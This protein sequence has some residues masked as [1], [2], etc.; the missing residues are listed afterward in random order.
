M[1]TSADLLTAT[2]NYSGIV[3]VLRQNVLRYLLY[4]VL[5]TL[6]FGQN[7]VMQIFPVEWRREI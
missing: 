7:R 5:P 4:C 1:L 6:R 2:V 3:R